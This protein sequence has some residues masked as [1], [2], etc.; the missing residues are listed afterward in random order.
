M[1]ARLGAALAMAALLVVGTAGC[2]FITPQATTKE[3]ET[4]NGVN[5]KVGT[6]DIR[7]ATLIS[8]DGEDASLLVTFSNSAK[9]S[10]ALTLQYEADGAK[11]ELTV[12]V[13]GNG[14][15]SFGA[16]GETQVVLRGITATA[17]SLFPVYFQYGDA[18]GEQL[19]LPVLTTDFKEYTGLAPT[20][21]PTVTPTPVPSAT[22][23]PT[24]TPE[25]PAPDATP[26]P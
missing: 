15:T 11:T 17:G 3:V 26:A 14:N 16:D 12:P 22:P 18:E 24:G 25:A 8:D 19:L 5:G 9:E 6:I 13:A 23:T 21:L 20:P 1:R 7:N 4:A 2:A 10:R